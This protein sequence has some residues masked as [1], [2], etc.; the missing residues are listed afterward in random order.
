MPARDGAAYLAGL[1]DG[2]EIWIDG[3]RAYI[4]AAEADAQPDE[5]GIH[6]PRPETLWTARGYFPTIYSRMVE[7]LQVL[8]SSGLMAIPSEATT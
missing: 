1:R 5:N 3:Q 6:V 8:G 7:L 4:R 2:R